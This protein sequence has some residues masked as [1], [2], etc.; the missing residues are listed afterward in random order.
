MSAIRTI[1]P[2][3]RCGALT[4]TV[5]GGVLCSGCLF[6]GGSKSAPK[7]SAA[8][9]EPA[10]FSHASKKGAAG[11]QHQ[12]SL[13]ELDRLAYNYADRYNMVITSATEE[14]KRGNTDPVQRRRAIQL[15]LRGV[16]AMNDIVSGND[17]YLQS[18][19]LVVS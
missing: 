4:L 13:E 14:L 3:F 8:A 16:Q 1:L 17:P 6:G 2:L 7:E 19:D 12:I 11:Q 9:D 18:L 10:P 5:L 15:R